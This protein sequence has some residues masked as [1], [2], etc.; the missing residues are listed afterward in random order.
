MKITIVGTGYVGLSNAMLLAQ[1]NE[2]VALDVVEE[3]IDL[4]NNKKSPIVDKEIES[5]LQNNSLHFFATLDKE[6]AYQNADFIIV[7]TPLIMILKLITL[8]PLQ[9]SWS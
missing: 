6:Q 1:H 7:A 4:L 3:K 5:F 2:V 9:L 8:I